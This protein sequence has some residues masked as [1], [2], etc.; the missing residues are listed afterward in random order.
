MN[1]ILDIALKDLM[2]LSRDVKTFMFL[3]FMPIVLT[4]VFGFAFGG[5]AASGS[6]PRLPVAVIDKDG[7]FSDVCLTGPA[8]FVFEGRIEI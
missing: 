1:R 5:A 7:G 6:D 3:L 2:Q 8:E 4:L